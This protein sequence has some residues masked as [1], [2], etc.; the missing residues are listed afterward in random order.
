MRRL[1]TAAALAVLAAIPAPAAAAGSNLTQAGG[2]RFPARSYVLA[3]PPGA[4]VDPGQVEVLENGK[5]V[6]D[7]SVS[8]PDTAGSSKFGVVL[9]IDA[10]ETMRG[11]PIEDAMTAARAFAKHRNPQEPLAVIAFNAEPSTLLPL[12]TDQSRID[13]ALAS[14]PSLDARGTHINDAVAAALALLKRDAVT[15]GS[16]VVLSDGADTGSLRSADDVARQ[17]RGDGIRIFT[18]ALRSRSFDPSVMRSLASGAGGRYTETASSRSLAGIYDSLGSELANQ[19]LIRY[20]SLAG[21][22]SDVR[23]DVRTADGAALATTEYVSPPL[24]VRSTPRHEKGGFW[25]SVAAMVVISFGAALVLALGILGLLAARPRGHTLA[26][27]IEGFGAKVEREERRKRWGAFTSGMLGGAEKSLERTRWWT[28]FKEELEVARIGTPGVQV[29][30]WSVV[31][32]LVTMWLLRAITG[33]GIVAVLG[34]GVPLG[35]RAYIK[36][37]LESQRRLFGDQLADNLQ[38]IA[39][40][41]RAGHSFV[42]ALSVAVEDAPEPA[43]SEFRRVVADERLGVPLESAIG[44]VVRRMDS[45]DLEQVVLVATLQRETGGNTA[46]V[47]DRV[48]ETIRERSELRGLVR[49]LTAQGRMSRWVVTSLPVGLLLLITAINPGYMDPLWGTTI[50]RVLLVLGASMVAAGSL[51]IKRIVTIE[52]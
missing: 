51:V 2:A 32:M 16:I 43:K 27:R 7:L 44:T 30:M 36:R 20:R 10:T 4:S 18:V 23:V 9:L 40:A 6:R 35:V 41:M 47:I 22:G 29:L 12:T 24:R 1:A 14:R 8:R 39:S 25:G 5:G 46:E 52:V 21:L 15:A 34:L 3:L 49:I 33:S 38:V 48:A 11:R 31:G 50:G 28:A 42:G 19:Y 37:R 26:E 13:A 17:A 45:R